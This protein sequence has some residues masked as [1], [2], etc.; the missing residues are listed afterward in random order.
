MNNEGLNKLGRAINSQTGETVMEMFG[1]PNAFTDG[2]DGISK[3]IYF[4][5]ETIIR[6]LMPD[7]RGGFLGGEFGYACEYENDIFR[8]FPDYQD[9]DDES[10]KDWPPFN[11]LHK[12]SGFQAKWYKWIGRDMEVSQSTINAEQWR[13]IFDECWASIPAD[14]RE[15][16][17]KESAHE[18]TPEYI[19]QKAEASTRMMEILLH[20]EKHGCK[21]R[22][23]KCNTCG[24]QYEYQ[25]W[26]TVLVGS[27]DKC[28]RKHFKRMARPP[29]ARPD[30]H[31]AKSVLF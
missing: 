25:D 26:A 15:R 2:S 13:S 19:K 30:P 21:K 22:K 12:P 24:K 16:A 8:I 18:S 10:S 23:R 11:F 17:K 31:S 3:G 20:P 5:S 28:M 14:T 27:C 4:L 29:R 9:W 6:G 1:P 7:K